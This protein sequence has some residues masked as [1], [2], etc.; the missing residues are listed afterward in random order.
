MMKPALLALGLALGLAGCATTWETAYEQVDPA[1]AAGWRV[2]AVEV[3]VPETLTTSDKNSYLPDFDIVWHGEPAGD[4]GAQA[5]AILEEGIEK[6]SA[7]QRGRTAVPIVAPLRPLRAITPGL[8]DGRQ[9]SGV[10]NIHEAGQL[11]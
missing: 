6:G 8:R 2:A 4:R 9:N 5:A 7:G 1:Q 11:F 3:A 10:H